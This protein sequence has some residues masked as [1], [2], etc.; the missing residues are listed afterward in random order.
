MFTLGGVSALIINVF[1][2]GQSSKE[3]LAKKFILLGNVR[4]VK[5][6][7]PLKT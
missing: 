3:P 6:V 7:Q 4:V 5:A 1:K 2:L